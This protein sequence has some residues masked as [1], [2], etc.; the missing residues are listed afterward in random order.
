MLLVTINFVQ[1]DEAT[2]S[3]KSEVITSANETQT[4]E[5]SLTEADP[6]RRSIA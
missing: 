4:A 5:S 1:A 6:K 3:E 2:V